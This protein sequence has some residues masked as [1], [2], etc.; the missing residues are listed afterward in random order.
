[1]LR[2]VALLEISRSRPATGVAGLP[3]TVRN[4]S[5]NELATKFLKGA[6]TFTEIFQEVISNGFQ[7]FRSPAIQF[8]W[9]SLASAT[10]IYQW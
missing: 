4:A 9:N 3:S 5:K 6:L 10:F 8:C 7:Q 1:M 2:K